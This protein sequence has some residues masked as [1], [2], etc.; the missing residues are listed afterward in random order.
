MKKAIFYISAIG[1]LTLLINIIQ[2]L[3]TDLKRLTDYGFGYLT[4]KIILFVVFLTVA[5][6]T[7]KY[8]IKKGD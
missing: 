1:S 4:G 8:V 2:I 7:R 6:I 5:I 3:I